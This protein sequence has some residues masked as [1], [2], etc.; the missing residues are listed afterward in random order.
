LVVPRHELVI[1]VTSALD[2]RQPI[3]GM[4]WDCLLP[5]VDEPGSAEDDELLAERL[6]QLAIPP[7]AGAAGGSAKAT[8]DASVENSALP[9]GTPVVVEPV[10]GGWQLRFGSWP[11]IEAGHGEWRESAPLGRSVVATAAWHDDTFIADLQIIST[12]HRVRVELHTATGTA[13]AT[14]N[15]VP[16]TGPKLELHLTAPLM[17]RPDVA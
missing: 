14:W 16:L 13:V 4:F 10:D 3:P 1:A 17:T 5:G 15:G 2:E 9:D 12:P 8:V 11:S 6:R 7:V